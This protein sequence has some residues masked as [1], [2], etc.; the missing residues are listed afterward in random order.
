MSWR[1]VYRIN[2]VRNKRRIQTYLDEAGL[3]QTSFAELAGVTPQAVSATM[4]GKNDSDTVLDA[5]RRI[6]VPEKLLCDPRRGAR[7]A[8]A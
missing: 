3:S 2:R 7:E 1:S 4:N 8:V 6:G 5:L